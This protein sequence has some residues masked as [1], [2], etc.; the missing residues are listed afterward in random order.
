MKLKNDSYNVT[1]STRS[2]QISLAKFKTGSVIVLTTPA[3]TSN[4]TQLQNYGDQSGVVTNVISPKHANLEYIYDVKLNNG[5]VISNVLKQGVV[6]FDKISAFSIN[7][8]VEIKKDAIIDTDGKNI[9]AYRGFSG[10]ITKVT[11][12]HQLSSNFYYQIILDNGVVVAKILEQDLQRYT[13]KPVHKDGWSSENGVTKY[14]VNGAAIV[15]E[16]KIDGHWYNFASNGVQS[17]GLTTL[18]H[19]TVF[20]DMKSGQMAYGYVWT[21][22]TLMFFDTSDGHALIGVRHYSGGVEY[23]GSDFKQVRNQSV[24][25]GDKIYH[26]NKDG[27]TDSIQSKNPTTARYAKN[28]SVYIRNNAD[29][30]VNGNHN[31]KICWAKC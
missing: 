25:I 26:F 16:K 8:R 18:A 2:I 4:G 14:Y 29:Q 3:K 22:G 20:Y 10:T 1:P 12:Y 5:M 9:S 11:R 6:S 13:N 21:N 28:T 23:Y 7:N 19:K 24:T 27:D 15:G 30:S 31:L 17:K